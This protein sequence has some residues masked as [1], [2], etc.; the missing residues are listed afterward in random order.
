MMDFCVFPFNSISLLLR[1]FTAIFALKTTTKEQNIYNET[2][3]FWAQFAG[4]SGEENFLSY[5]QVRGH[6]ISQ[7][8][9]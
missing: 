4:R 7:N 3:L 6:T 1:S 8:C 2:Y 9:Q 5:L